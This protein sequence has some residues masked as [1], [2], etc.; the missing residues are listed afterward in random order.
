VGF[1]KCPPPVH[2]ITSNSNG[3]WHGFPSQSFGDVVAS[4]KSLSENGGGGGWGMLFDVVL[5][6]SCG[7][8]TVASRILACIVSVNI[9]VLL[10]FGFDQTPGVYR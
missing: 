1:P 4:D 3:T 9:E 6:V 5:R 8:Y 10:S 2:L 7:N